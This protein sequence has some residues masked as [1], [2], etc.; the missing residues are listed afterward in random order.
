[1]LAGFSQTDSF[2]FPDI[3]E[4]D[5]SI[6]DLES[7]IDNLPDFEALI[8]SLEDTKGKCRMYFAPVRNF[9]ECGI[10]CC[11]QSYKNTLKPWASF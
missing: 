5:N 6:Q 11:E 8:A 3:S 9:F 10:E 7:S 1:M 4:L 2:S